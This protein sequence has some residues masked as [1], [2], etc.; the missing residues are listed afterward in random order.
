M[1]N[2]PFTTTIEMGMPGGR[3]G[4]GKPMAGANGGSN[5]EQPSRFLPLMILTLKVCFR[6]I[7]IYY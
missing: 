1:T 4:T 3:S 7:L 5:A 6:K 2:I